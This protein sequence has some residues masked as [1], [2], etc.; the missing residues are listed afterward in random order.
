MKR[1]KKDTAQAFSMFF[2]IRLSITHYACSAPHSLFEADMVHLGW[3]IHPMSGMLHST[4][5]TMMNPLLWLP[6][7]R[8]AQCC[9][10]NIYLTSA[11]LAVF[12]NCSDHG[13][14]DPLHNS[15]SKLERRGPFSYLNFQK[16]NLTESGMK[17]IYFMKWNGQSKRKINK[18]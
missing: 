2:D 16:Q 6:L 4:F 15:S 8:P 17:S 1:R 14:G 11:N 7:T 5:P 3:S 12:I 18:K 13:V 10:W 9:C